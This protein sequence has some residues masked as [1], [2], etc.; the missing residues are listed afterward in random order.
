M[1]EDTTDLERQNLNT[2]ALLLG[3]SSIE[4]FY[5]AIFTAYGEPISSVYHLLLT[6]LLTGALYAL[7]HIGMEMHLSLNKWIGDVRFEWYNF[8][9]TWHYLA[10]LYSENRKAWRKV[11]IMVFHS[12]SAGLIFLLI[13]SFSLFPNNAGI[14]MLYL[15]FIAGIFLPLCAP[16]ITW[17]L[18]NVYKE[19]T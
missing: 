2:K 19:L 1:A 14:E 3:L 10:W 6:S 7:G 13:G 18:W 9:T 16:G 11:A 8:F 15:S 5:I 12:L 17:L 4:A